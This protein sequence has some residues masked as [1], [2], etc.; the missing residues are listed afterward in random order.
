MD[1]PSLQAFLAVAQWRSFSLAA[2]LLHLTQP[3]I[4]K[5]IAN[6]EH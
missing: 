3:A 1:I 2:Q 6:L 4:S 5:R